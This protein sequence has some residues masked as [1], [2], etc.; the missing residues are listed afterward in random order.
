MGKSWL[1]H[2]K[3]LKQEPSLNLDQAQESLASCIEIIT[4]AHTWKAD[5]FPIEISPK[6]CWLISYF[7][8]QDYTDVHT[9]TTREDRVPGFCQYMGFVLCSV[10]MLCVGGHLSIPPPRECGFSGTGSWFCSRFL[11]IQSVPLD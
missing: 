7:G 6:Q 2:S 3:R 1:G 10:F 8:T 4:D 5:T 9:G 11:F